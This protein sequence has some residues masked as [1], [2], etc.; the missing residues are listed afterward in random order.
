MQAAHLP[1]G[2]ERDALQ[3]KIRQLAVAVHM[4]GWHRRGFNRRPNY[5][6]SGFGLGNGCMR[7]PPNDTEAPHIALASEG[8]PAEVIA[9]IQ[10][11]ALNGIA[12]V[13]V[14]A[15]AK[16]SWDHRERRYSAMAKHS[17]RGIILDDKSQEQPKAK[18]CADGEANAAAAEN[19]KG[20]KR[21]P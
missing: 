19:K 11:R 17:D 4:N 20:N 9:D 5:R 14:K 12:L 10:R 8:Q 7:S 1:H 3:K 2:P 16:A 13:A 15:L 18:E 21:P 6:L